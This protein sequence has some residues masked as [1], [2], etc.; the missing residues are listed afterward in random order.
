[1]GLGND[2]TTDRGIAALVGRM[3]DGF[4]RLV[5]QHLQLARMELVEDA[6]AMGLSVASLAVFVPFVLVG[7]FFLC[8]ALAVVLA[9]WLGYAG[10][11]AAVGAA[12]LVG[13]GIGIYGAIQRLRT[14]NLMDGTAQELNRSVAALAAA[15]QAPAPTAQATP[16]S[17]SNTAVQAAP[18]NSLKEQRPNGL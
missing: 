3:A 2:Q 4:S 5:T 17:P 16:A 13:G 1:M 7:Y 12:N 11:L 8:G 9:P 15:P 14:R 6:K 18:K 10:G